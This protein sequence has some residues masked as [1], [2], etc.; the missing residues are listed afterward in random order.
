MQL[1]LSILYSPLLGYKICCVLR[2]F[3][4]CI[5]HFVTNLY[6]QVVI[7]LLLSPCFYLCYIYSQIYNV[8]CISYLNSAKFV[9]W[10]LQE[11]N[12]SS[13]FQV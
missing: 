11:L 13:F 1:I 6:L 5:K 4:I 12:I 7:L 10:I 3:N 2:K 8:M 9:V